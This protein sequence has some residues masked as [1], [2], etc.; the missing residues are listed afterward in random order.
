MDIERDD[1]EIIAEMRAKS[2]RQ[3]LAEFMGALSQLILHLDLPATPNMLA[4]NFHGGLMRVDFARLTDDGQH[5][6]EWFV[7]LNANFCDP[8]FGARLPLPGDA[9][10]H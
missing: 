10:A 6:T 3:V 1:E 9:K 4:V 7:G 5:I 8:A 2:T